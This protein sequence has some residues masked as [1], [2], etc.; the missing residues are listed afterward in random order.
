MTQSC[1]EE[2]TAIAAERLHGH[3]HSHEGLACDDP[4]ARSSAAR[5]LAP[6]RQERRPKWPAEDLGR[7]SEVAVK[8]RVQSLHEANPMLGHRGCRLAVTYPE[9]LDMQV[10]AITEAVIAC[11]KK[12]VDAKAEIMIPLG[13]H[14][15]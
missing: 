9:I 3:L 10:T 13:R 15:R 1:P 7:Q 11:K 8:S 4:P 14:R 6:R 2:A 5:V 12:K